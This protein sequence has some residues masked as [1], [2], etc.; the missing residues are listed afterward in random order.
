M[1]DAAGAVVQQAVEAAGRAAAGCRHRP[2]SLERSIAGHLAPIV[3]IKNPC[4]YQSQTR[5]IGADVRRAVAADPLR[6]PRLDARCRV[7]EPG[8]L[9][10]MSDNVP[11]GK[12][13][14]AFG[15]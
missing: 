10:K 11:Y 12:C 6:L 13:R 2:L 9:S 14:C 5:Q 4:Q 7:N 1:V 8:A 3:R 15:A